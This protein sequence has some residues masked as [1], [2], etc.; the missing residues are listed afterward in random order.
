MPQLA[1]SLVDQRAVAMFKEWINGLPTEVDED[2]EP[3]DKQ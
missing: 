1:T 2:P 3:D